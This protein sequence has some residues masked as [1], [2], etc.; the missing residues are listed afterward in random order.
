MGLMSTFISH[1]AGLRQVYLLAEDLWLYH[2]DKIEYQ[3]TLDMVFNTTTSLQLLK[4]EALDGVFNLQKYGEYLPISEYKPWN[5][6]RFVEIEKSSSVL[7]KAV[8]P[9][10]IYVVPLNIVACLAMYFLFQFLRKYKVSIYLL[11][12]YFIKTV[13]LQSLLEGNVAY[14][15]FVCFGHIETSFSF[16]FGD[17]ISLL[18]MMVFLWII[19]IFSFTFYP[20]IGRYLEKRSSSFIQSIR[21][22]NSGLFFISMRQLIRNF[23]RGAVFYFLYQYYAVE[24][25]LLIVIEVAIVI[26]T[27]AFELRNKIFL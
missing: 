3:G 22:C 18:F 12:F 24:L 2:Y 1:L 13:L 9:F 19:I 11:K 21:G 7:I 10:F 17:K 16:K 8:F 23:I 20:L 6:Q 15:S 5:R 27:V 14:F 4:L 25:I 26:L